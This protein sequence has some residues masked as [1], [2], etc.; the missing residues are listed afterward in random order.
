MEGADQCFQLPFRAC[1]VSGS[2]PAAHVDTVQL[3]LGKSD[4]SHLGVDLNAEEH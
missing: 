1:L 4:N 3:V 2:L